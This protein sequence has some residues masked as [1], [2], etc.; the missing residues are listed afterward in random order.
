LEHED[1]L[2]RA[3]QL[4]ASGLLASDIDAILNELAGI[5]ETVTTHYQ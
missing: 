4:A 1:V 2:K 5:I 3:S